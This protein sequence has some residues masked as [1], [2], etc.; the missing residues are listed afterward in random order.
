MKKITFAVFLFA[1]SLAAQVQIG[2]G[3]QI[4]GTGSFTLTTTGTSGP[5]TYTGGILNIPQYSGGGVGTINGTAGA[6]TFTG[7]GVS[8]V[9]TTCTFTAGTGTPAGSPLSFQFNNTTFGGTLFL[10]DSTGADLLGVRTFTSK[11][12]NQTA[13]VTGFGN[14]T[15]SGIST[16]LAAGTARIEIPFSY[17]AE[18]IPGFTSFSNGT[19]L[20]DLRG[21]QE[22]STLYNWAYGQGPLFGLYA[23]NNYDCHWDALLQEPSHPTTFTTVLCDSAQMEL[24]SIGHNYGVGGG[25]GLNLAGWVTAQGRQFTLDTPSQGIKSVQLMTLD[26]TGIGDCHN[27]DTVGF[28][29]GGMTDASGEGFAL[30]REN[31]HIMPQYIGTITAV[32]PAASTTAL[33]LTCGGNCGKAGNGQHLVNTTSGVITGTT[34][35][36]GLNGDGSSTVVVT[37]PSSTI[38]PSTCAV[39]T[40]NLNTAIHPDGAAPS[41]SFQIT[42][43]SAFIASIP[44]ILVGNVGGG[45]PTFIEQQLP[46]SVGSLSGGQQTITMPVMYGYAAGASICQGSIVGRGVEF[47]VFG[48]NYIQWVLAVPSTNTLTIGE[49]MGGQLNSLNS[50]GAI[51]IYKQS[52]VIDAFNHTTLAVDGLKLST[53]IAAS[54]WSAS[55]SVVLFHHFAAIVRGHQWV[56]DIDSPY[57]TVQG[58]N[59]SLFALHYNAATYLN[60]GGVGV[61]NSNLATHG[62][63]ANP[64]IFARLNQLWAEG[65]LMQRAPEGGPTGT[66]FGACVLCIGPIDSGSSNTSYQ[67]FDAVNTTG[68]HAGHDF[69]TFTPSTGEMSYTSKWTSDLLN[70]VTGFQFNGSAPSGHCLVGNGTNYVDAAC[71]AGTITA[72]TGASPIVSSGGTTPA[73]SCPTCG[74]TGSP[75]S[76]FASTTSAQLASIISDETGS[77]ALVFGTAP[78]ITLPNATG[79]SL[80]TGVTGNLPNAN[81]A[82]QTANT[83]LGALTATTPSGLAMPSCPT[84]GGNALTWTS[85]VGFGC[86]NITGG[87]ASVSNSDGTLTISPTTGAVVAS[88]ALGHANTWT[89]L[90]T[91]VG[92]NF[93]GVPIAT[94]ISGLGVGIATFLGTP[95]SANLAAA[96]TDETGTGVAVFSASPALTGVPTAPTAAPGTNTTQLATTAF[97]LAAGGSGTV[98][99]TAGA[100]TVTKCVLGNGSADITV[101]PSCSTDGAGNMTL[102]SLLLNGTTPGSELF[103]AGTGSIPALTAN[104]AG[105]AAP[106]TGGTS[107]LIKFPA[108]MT[109]GI[110]HFAATATGDGVLESALTSSLV[111]LTTDVTGLL[112]LSAVSAA[113]A[114]SSSGTY[115]FN[116][117]AITTSGVISNNATGGTPLLPT[118]AML[119]AANV[120]GSPSRIAAIAYGA[121]GFFSAVG[122]GG[123]QASPTAVTATT[124]IGGVNAF[125]YNGTALN[126]PIASFRTFANENQTTSAAGSYADIATTPNGSTTL[127]QVLKFE[128]DGGMTTPGVTGGD[129]GA[130]TLNAAGLYINGVAVGTSAGTVS[131]VGFTGG[132]ISVA[133]PTSTPAFTVAGTSGGVVYFSSA[134]T[135]ASSAALTANV[136]T[137]GGGAGSAPSNSLCTENGTSLTCTDTGGVISPTFTASGTTAGFVDFPQG[138]TSVSVA[139]CNTATSICEQAPTAVTSY[140]LVKPGVAAQGTRSATLSG[141][142][143]T[144]SIS[145]DTGH[146][147]TVTIGSGTS[148]GSTSLCSTALCTAGT[149]RVNAYADITTACGTTGTYVINLIY[150]DDQGS[151]TIP[152]NIN[153][154]G[155]VPATGI[156]TTTSTSNFGENAQIIRSTGAAS[157]NYS[158]TATACG[159]AGPM[160]GKLYLSVEA[161]Q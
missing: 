145:G 94:G 86:N 28:Y 41:V 126:G 123:T 11:F 71:P 109:A 153:G 16:A 133:T 44:T 111:S 10:T 49:V 29:N 58:I 113:T 130:G 96:L 62:G 32:T 90:Q 160:V 144:E 91:M 22:N 8:C 74:V 128:N 82:T 24:Y 18:A 92:T 75:L 127:T 4:G 68:L 116:N 26:C 150:T 95:S 147:A 106:A 88:L 84:S 118:N 83:V 100:L 61:G 161:V 134:S 31:G 73:L 157:I 39:L 51:K 117:N 70:A 9:T 7:S 155:A 99:H 143:L 159:T 76:Q 151:K 63:W 42:T 78:V 69:L 77:G 45:T 52:V 55:D 54:T 138:T 158:T 47:Q 108:T 40:S 131:S 15:T 20:R 129:K 136:L 141:A 146:S 37:S 139:P 104:S 142:V 33:T 97:V 6:F 21:G 30:A 132:L 115:N 135:W 79:L 3:V 50:G 35:A 156:L 27:Y 34:T 67:P 64:P 19:L 152:I 23:P 1:S 148:I 149:Y 43:S 81:L 57:W 101:D 65:I 80:A 13:Q 102:V 87:V 66:G 72:V 48:Q 110:A 36:V 119:Y 89:A 112:P 25:I 120:S 125:A 14:G 122:I 17:G 121:Q 103:T 124:Q 60:L 2:K 85:G 140:L 93:T 59:D 105:F 56:S 5:A 12:S 114:P 53:D 154:T 38:N 107:Y 137:K 46:S 98:T